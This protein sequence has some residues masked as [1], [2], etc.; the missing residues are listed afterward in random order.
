MC[1]LLA[2]HDLARDFVSLPS[3][4]DAATV[5]LSCNSADLTQA[6][7]EEDLIKVG[8]YYITLMT[9]GKMNTCYIASCEGKNPDGTYEMEHLT[10]VQRGSDLKWKQPAR[11]D[12]INLQAGSIVECGV[13]GEW[14]VSQERNM[15]FTLWNHAY[16]SNLVKTMFT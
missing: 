11:I 6:H 12:K 4:K 3:N 1:A 2:E 16:I 10:R 9:K 5:L 7:N 15:T 8:R 13:D 14:D